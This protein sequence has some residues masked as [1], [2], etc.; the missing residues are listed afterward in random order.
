MHSWRYMTALGSGMVLRRCGSLRLHGASKVWT[1]LNANESEPGDVVVAACEG[2][3]A[4]AAQYRFASASSYTVCSWKPGDSYD[5]REAGTVR[6]HGSLVVVDSVSRVLRE[7][8]PDAIVKELVNGVFEVRGLTEKLAFALRAIASVH[9]WIVLVENER[10]VKLEV[11]REGA[12]KKLLFDVR[13]FPVMSS[14]LVLDSEDVGVVRVSGRLTVVRSVRSFVQRFF[15]GAVVPI[16]GLRC[17]VVRADVVRVNELAK[18]HGWKVV[19]DADGVVVVDVRG[20][21]EHR[22][23]VTKA[24][25]EV[26]K[27]CCYVG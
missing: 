27:C 9:G 19:A 14:E 7:L 24:D 26:D 5:L 2:L 10:F 22:V 12:D 23:E 17:W 18:E 11:G 4:G 3:R 1:M 13:G 16:L 20:C 15:G 25:F 8:F 21:E 6:V